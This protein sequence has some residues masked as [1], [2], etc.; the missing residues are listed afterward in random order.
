VRLL[1]G[2]RQPVLLLQG[3]R[4][5]LVSVEGARRIA[6]G[7]PWWRYEEA[8]DIG[9]VPM[10]EAPDWTFRAIADWMAREGAPAVEKARGAA[11]RSPAES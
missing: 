1:A 4:D 10:L 3:D 5:R 8:H 2:I 6:R 9:H 11:L 7:L